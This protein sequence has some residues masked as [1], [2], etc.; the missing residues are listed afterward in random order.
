MQDD[1]IGTNM[2]RSPTGSRYIK[3]ILSRNC[4]LKKRLYK[5]KYEN[6][7]KRRKKRKNEKRT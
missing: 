5:I 4:K 1:K 3:K 2:D 6:E 7:E